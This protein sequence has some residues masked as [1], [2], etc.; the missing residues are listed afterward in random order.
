MVLRWP[1]GK[2]VKPIGVWPLSVASGV[3]VVSRFSAS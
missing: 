2:K 3:I 1:V